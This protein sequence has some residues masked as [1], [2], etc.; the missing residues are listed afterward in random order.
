MGK[1]EG[2]A[3]G[4]TRYFCPRRGYV[5]VDGRWFEDRRY[6]WER[7]EDTKMG[8]NGRDV[9]MVAVLLGISLGFLVLIGL[10]KAVVI[11]VE[12][13]IRARSKAQKPKGED[14]ESGGEGRSEE[15]EIK[16]LHWANRAEAMADQDTGIATDNVP[17]VDTIVDED[18]EELPGYM[19][20]CS[21]T[22]A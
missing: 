12:H 5:C 14:T 13:W 21:K 2:A 6:G 10:T 1:T 11:Y 22:L 8:E 16:L 17:T 7:A 19:E 4:S 3:S 18:D 20:A 9:K 15:E